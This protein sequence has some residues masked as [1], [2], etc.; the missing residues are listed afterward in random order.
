M[1]P[2]KGHENS[3]YH[4]HTICEKEHE[5]AVAVG[6]SLPPRK[7]QG[8]PLTSESPI[9]LGIQQM[10]EKDHETLSKLHNV[11]FHIALQRLPFTAFQNQVGCIRELHAVKFTGADENEKACKNFIFGIS[12]YLFEECKEKIAFSK[13]YHILCN[14]S[15]ENSI[16]EQ[17]VLCVIFTDPETFK[18]TR[19]FLKLLHQLIFRMPQV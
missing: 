12:K 9:Y 15:T 7:M 17:D 19:S 3:A 6:K 11:S 16:I 14:G 18:P 2:L 10:S 5:E 8:R 1:S 13:L 4:Q